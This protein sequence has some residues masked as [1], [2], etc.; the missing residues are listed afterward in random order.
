MKYPH[1]MKQ[2]VVDTI[3]GEHAQCECGAILQFDTDLY[4][5]VVESCKPCGYS[6]KLT[7]A[8]PRHETERQAPVEDPMPCETC[9]D[10]VGFSGE[11]TRRRWCNRCRALRNAVLSR[12]WYWKHKKLRKAS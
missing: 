9:G 10:P 4:G 3:A 12:E 11:G 6:R 7:P 1:E 5:Y 8:R 2:V